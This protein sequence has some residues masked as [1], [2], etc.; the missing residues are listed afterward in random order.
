M[1]NGHKVE[2]G[3]NLYEALSQ[4]WRES[5]SAQSLWIDALSINQR[6]KV[7]VSNQVRFMGRIYSAANGVIVW[8]GAEGRN[9]GAIFEALGHKGAGPESLLQMGTCITHGLR[10]LLDRDWWT[11]LWVVQ[12]ATF[13]KECIAR[14]GPFSAD[15]RRMI[16]VF[17][18]V[19][20]LL[21]GV[22]TGVFDETYAEAL[23]NDLEALDR[24]VSIF[25]ETRDLSGCPW[26]R[27][28]SITLLSGTSVCDATNPRDYIYGVLGLLPASLD[29][30]PDYAATVEE[31]FEAAAVRIMQ[32]TGSVEL[33]CAIEIRRDTDLKLPSWVPPFRQIWGNHM[34][35][36]PLRASTN[37]VVATSGKGMIE[38]TADIT[39]SIEVVGLRCGNL[40]AGDQFRDEQREYCRQVLSAWW[41]LLTGN[42]AS[43]IEDFHKRRFWLLLLRENNRPFDAHNPSTDLADGQEQPEARASSG[44]AAHNSFLSISKVRDLHQW[45]ATGSR[46][47]GDAAWFFKALLDLSSSISRA[48]FFVTQNG[49]AGLI[50]APAQAADNVAYLGNVEQ[51]FVLRRADTSPIPNAYKLLAMCSYHDMTKPEEWNAPTH[52][53]RHDLNAGATVMVELLQATEVYKSNV[54][55]TAVRASGRSSL[56]DALKLWFETGSNVLRHE[57]V[58]GVAL[59]YC[60]RD[61]ERAMSAVELIH[62]E[63]YWVEGSGSAGATLEQ[64]KCPRVPVKDIDLICYCNAALTVYAAAIELT[65]DAA[66]SN[67][68]KAPLAGVMERLAGIVLA[69]AVLLLQSRRPQTP[70]DDIFELMQGLPSLRAA[71]K[72]RMI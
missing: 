46:P 24:I 19:A 36:V 39:D 55:Y 52:P 67:H 14:C 47:G 13:G 21:E 63:L 53:D 16:A 45:L 18:Q 35:S 25:T 6:D 71:Y 61:V 22:E 9:S 28:D 58:K 30:K 15:F 8:L 26:A 38:L 49:Y 11:R 40:Y 17:E 69:R 12:E 66:I 60:G 70:S 10:D 48:S 27:R 41:G 68:K 72:S 64:L 34:G 4:I 2:I 20:V 3:E 5:S 57:F 59:Y 33:L 50:C 23:E 31:V 51:P 43:K 54:F 65:H 37:S 44:I 29:V 62:Q 1:V 32:W 7:E 42:L 56:G